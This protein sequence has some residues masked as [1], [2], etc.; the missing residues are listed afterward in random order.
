[1]HPPA[2]RR[3]A[4]K[5][6]LFA[7]TALSYAMVNLKPIVPGHVLVCPKRPLARF[8]D[9]SPD[10]VADLWLLAQRVAATLE[11]HYGCSASTF[12]I[13]DGA[14]AGQ[15]VTHVHIHVLPRRDGQFARNDEVYDR[16]ED[17]EGALGE[18]RERLTQG[19]DADEDR[20]PRSREEMA[21][22]AAELRTLF[23]PAKFDRFSHP[24]WMK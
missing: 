2:T 4:N 16:V 6:E 20:R 15:T 10:E 3:T 23:P 1:M 5:S 22:E 12:A 13:Q 18:G 11:P 7:H 19:M 14:A 8:A 21:A 17:N 9:L 24:T